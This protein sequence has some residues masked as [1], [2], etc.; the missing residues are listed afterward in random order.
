MICFVCRQPVDPDKASETPTGE[1]VH[2]ACQV[3]EL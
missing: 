3:A 1:P 2:F